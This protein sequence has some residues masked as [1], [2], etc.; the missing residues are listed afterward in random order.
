[1]A[2]KENAPPPCLYSKERISEVW[3][4]ATRIS[5]AAQIN[6]APLCDSDAASRLVGDIVHRVR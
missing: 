1:L 3:N 4:A 6:L 5:F 2:V